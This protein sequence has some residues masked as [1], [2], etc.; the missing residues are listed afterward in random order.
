[1][2]HTVSFSIPKRQLGR[3]DVKFTV[4][5]NGEPLG[6]L[7]VSRGAVDWAP[8]GCTYGRRLTWSQAAALFEENGK[9]CTV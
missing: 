1:M 8:A 6:T 7:H 4:H 5:L 9:R 2:G 3:E